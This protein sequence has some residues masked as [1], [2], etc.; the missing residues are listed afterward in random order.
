MQRP[1]D[2]I[3]HSE[4]RSGAGECRLSH[5]GGLVLYLGP[6]EERNTLS[7]RHVRGHHP[8]AGH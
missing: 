1:T 3:V 5:H 2:P 7:Y 6:F 4:C 8:R